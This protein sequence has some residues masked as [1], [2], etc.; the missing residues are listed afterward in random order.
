MTRM[1]DETRETLLALYAL[2]DAEGG[3]DSDE[4]PEYH[5]GYC[6]GLELA[7]VHINQLLNEDAPPDEAWIEEG[8]QRFKAQSAYALNQKEG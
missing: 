3:H 5:R 1:S 7:L 6:V 2:I 4:G 8:W